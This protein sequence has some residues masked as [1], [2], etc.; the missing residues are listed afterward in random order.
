MAKKIKT[1]KNLPVVC[2]YSRSVIYHC[3]YT[4][5]PFHILKLPITTADYYVKHYC[6]LDCEKF[7]GE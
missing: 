6:Q 3:E 5:C 1:K 7:N 4:D 2:S